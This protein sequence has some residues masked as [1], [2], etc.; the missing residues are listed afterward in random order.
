ML[1]CPFYVPAS[2]FFY[3]IHCIQSKVIIQLE[4]SDTTL[5]LYCVMILP[6]FFP[7]ASFSKGYHDILKF[8]SCL[9]SFWNTYKKDVP[10][11]KTIFSCVPQT[12]LKK[13]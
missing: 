1:L 10:F 6:V 9:F 12:L 2:G 13:M 11:K 3:Y 4:E 7:S 5:H 8:C